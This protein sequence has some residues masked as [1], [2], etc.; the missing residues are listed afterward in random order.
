MPPLVVCCLSICRM[1]DSVRSSPG[2]ISV[3]IMMVMDDDD[4]NNAQ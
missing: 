4:D 1:G 3:I 2:E